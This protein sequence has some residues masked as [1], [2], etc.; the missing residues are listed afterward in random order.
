MTL[1]MYADSDPEYHSEPTQHGGVINSSVMYFFLQKTPQTVNAVQSI[2]RNVKEDAGVS[3]IMKSFLSRCT[4]QQTEDFH[5]QSQ[6][7]D[8]LILGQG[9]MYF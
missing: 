9:C 8:A 5:H 1:L 4:V 3:V 7:N 6:F 2:A